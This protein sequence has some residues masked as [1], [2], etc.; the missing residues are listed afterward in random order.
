MQPVL[1]ITSAVPGLIAIGGRPAGE[2]A[3]GEIV[4]PVAPRGAVY[5]EHRP[6]VNG[7]LPLT[8]R[9]TLS[10]GQIMPESVADLPGLSVVLWPNSVAELGLS[11]EAIAPAATQ[12]VKGTA[13][14]PAAVAMDDGSMRLIEPLGD[15]VG[16]ARL[17]VFQPNGGAWVSAHTEILWAAGAPRWPTSPDETALA[18]IEAALLGLTEEASGYMAP[19][20]AGQLD[21][22]DLTHV[23]GC[24]PLK[25]PDALGRTAVGLVRLVHGHLARVVPLY[26]AV[27]AIG[28][29]QG[30][31]RIRD[32]FVE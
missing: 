22:L 24:T 16:H 4:V 20:A 2:A 31:W 28:G 3:A 25:H 7:Y 29:T 13:L 11:P 26:Y 12:A 15:T 19:G 5:I 30:T 8:R 10:G 23:I 32:L 17:T 14:D 18:A 27:A 6:M 9:L 1:I 21:Q